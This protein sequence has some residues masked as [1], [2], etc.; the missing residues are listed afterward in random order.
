MMRLKNLVSAFAVVLSMANSAL[1]FHFS[2]LHRKSHLH[3]ELLF[4]SG[5]GGKS[6]HC[7]VEWTL[8][9][10]NGNSPGR[11]PPEIVSGTIEGSKCA[12]L[13]Y[14][15]FPWIVGVKTPPAAA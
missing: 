12:S 3:G 11:N 5:N 10:R 9:T 13:S 15:G 14:R 4:V 6:V 2:P 1:A 7:K 8:Y